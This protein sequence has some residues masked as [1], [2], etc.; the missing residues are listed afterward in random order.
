MS[1]GEEIRRF[2]EGSTHTTI[3]F[4]EIRAFHIKLAPIEESRKS[5]A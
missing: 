4:P 5:F 1:Q 2:G 3:Y